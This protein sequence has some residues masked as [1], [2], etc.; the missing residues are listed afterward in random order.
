MQLKLWFKKNE[1]SRLLVRCDNCNKVLRFISC[2]YLTIIG[3]MNSIKDGV[4]IMSNGLWN[5]VFYMLMIFYN[6]LKVIWK[7]RFNKISKYKSYWFK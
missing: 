5:G 2:K 4:K 1:Y 6:V 3:V 7:N